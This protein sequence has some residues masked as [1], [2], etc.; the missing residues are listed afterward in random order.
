M[1]MLTLRNAELADSIA[2]TKIHM[3]KTEAKNSLASSKTITQLKSKYQRLKMD[4][5]ALKRRTERAVQSATS[6]VT[7]L[8]I[9]I[10]YNAA[11]C[12]ENFLSRHI[13]K[14]T[15][16]DLPQI[17]L[18]LPDLADPFTQAFVNNCGSQ[19]TNR[20]ES[21]FENGHFGKDETKTSSL[22]L[23]KVV[24]DFRAGL[25][26]AVQLT[27]RLLQAGEMHKGDSGK[28]FHFGTKP[29]V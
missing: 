19:F 10:C 29:K 15:L 23:G 11:N 3:E 25:G 26:N 9:G 5:A 8:S 20:L 4:C 6:I 16:T 28:Y 2:Q 14:P 24:A 17:S 27:F 12:T 22:I 1:E 21:L 18:E 7:L 13:P